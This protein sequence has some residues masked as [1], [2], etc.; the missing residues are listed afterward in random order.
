MNLSTLLLLVPLSISLLTGRNLGCLAHPHP[1]FTPSILCPNAS[2]VWIAG[3]VQPVRWDIA[4][5]DVPP[6]THATG[7]IVLSYSN[8]PD[9]D[10]LHVGHEHEQYE[11]PQP[12]A[13]GFP[14]S[15]G[16]VN[17]VVPSGIPHGGHYYVMRTCTFAAR[18]LFWETG[19][20]L[21]VQPS[22]STVR[23]VPIKQPLKST[24]SSWSA[25]STTLATSLHGVIHR[26]PSKEFL[27]FLAG[28]LIGLVLLYPIARIT[29][30]MLLALAARQNAR[31]QP[32]LLPTATSEGR[33]DTEV[34][35]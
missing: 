18:F 25:L 23:E 1:L 10:P 26:L 35:R 28:F 6:D 12:L 29:R 17:A 31:S 2:S 30:D 11:Q 15:D 5:L 24:G 27:Q 4:G 34:P 9:G 3:S 13:D 22:P 33:E 32:V 14:L 20:V 7:Q 8:P 16:V 21:E 19:P